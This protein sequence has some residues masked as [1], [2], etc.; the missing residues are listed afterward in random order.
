MQDFALNNAFAPLIFRFANLALVLCTLGLAGHIRIQEHRTDLIGVIGSSTLFAI[1]VCP[2]AILHVFVNVY[3]EYFG[4]PIGLWEIRTKMFH[5]LTEL[6]F[7]C[8]FSSM[9]SLSFDDLFTS[10]LECTNYT[11]Y[12]RFSLPP[13][14][15]GSSGVEGTLADKICNQQIAL[16][17]FTFLSM[18][19]YIA[20]LVVSLF[21]I[22]VRV[23]R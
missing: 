15:A 10:P 19:M 23:K 4:R 3:I 5:T 16:V 13:A 17:A 12:A 18:I 20:V 21:R 6:V 8:L 14:T 2:L 22:F 7:I 1:I 9:L 11:P